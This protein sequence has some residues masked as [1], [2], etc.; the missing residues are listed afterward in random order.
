M[1][2]FSTCLSSKDYYIN[3]WVCLAGCRY[4]ENKNDP[5]CQ[6]MLSEHK[7]CCQTVSNNLHNWDYKLD[8]F[9]NHLKRSKQ[10]SH[11]ILWFSSIC[12][13]IF[14]PK[15]LILSD[16]FLSLNLREKKIPSFL[17][18]SIWKAEIC[19]S[20]ITNSLIRW[21]YEAVNITSR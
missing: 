18:W 1:S 2:V 5:C 21:E 9:S 12:S 4:I 13:A 20:H 14:T 16:S 8:C 15:C 17:I 11:K 7:L 3:T 19:F 6:T 10:W